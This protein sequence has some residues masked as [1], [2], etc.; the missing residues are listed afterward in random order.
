MPE[1]DV[2]DTY[3]A[4]LLFHVGCP[5]FSHETAGMF[6]NELVLLGAVAKTNV[7]DP[8]DWVATMIPEATKG[9]A[10]RERERLA[11]RIVRDGPAFGRLFDTASCEVAEAVA[12]RL[13]LSAGV[14]QALAEVA[15][16]W[17]GTGV[18]HGL[19]GDDIVLPARVARAAA[20]AAVLA[21]LGDQSAP[22][23]ILAAA[24]AFHAMT[25]ERPHRAALSAEQAAR[26]LR[27]ARR[28]RGGST[29][30]ARRPSSTLLAGR[31]DPPSGSAPGRAQRARDRG[32]APRRGRLLEPRSRSAARH[33]P[34]HGGTPCAAH[35]REGRRV[36]PGGARAVRS[37]AR[38]LLST[39]SDG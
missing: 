5:A 18:P 24:D 4:S 19:V 12:R 8:A 10:P 1:D 21:D 38:S 14:Q 33:L 13:G 11:S 16:W 20:D 2:A 28:A 6:G 34:A 17:D 22:A 29:G 37:R 25:Q 39:V 9:L 23:R 27:G 35:L 26:Q 31:T 36:E 7:A 3:Y 30:T 15:E 32:A